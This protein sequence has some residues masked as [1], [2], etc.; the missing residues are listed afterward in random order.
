MPATTC[1]TCA[2]PLPVAGADCPRCL[3]RL[4]LHL[5]SRDPDAEPSAVRPERERPA[6]DPAALAR[7]FPGLEIE[8]E[9]GRGGM[10]VVYRARQR[11]LGRTVALKLLAPELAGDR[12]F[13]ARFLREAR[14][15]AHLRHEHIVAVHDFGETEGLCW[16]LMEHVDGPDLRQM[17]ESGRL[18]A[19][20]A[21]RIVPQICDALS[22]AHALG[23]VHRDI[24]P[25]NVLLDGRGR[26]KIVDF[27][28][29][30]LI[31]PSG[32]TPTLT[33]AEQAMGTPHYMAPEQLRGARDVDHRADIYSLGVVFYEMLTGQLP[34]GRFEAPSRSV[35]VDVRLDEIVLR[36]LESQPERRYQSAVEVKGDVERV[37]RGPA[38]PRASPAR[39]E[40]AAVAKSRANRRQRWSAVSISV[41]IWGAPYAARGLWPLGWPGALALLVL[42]LLAG[43]LAWRRDLTRYPERP[44]AG[45]SRW[46]RADRLGGALLLVVLGLALT[47]AM[48]LASWERSTPHSTPVRRVD[49]ARSADADRAALRRL[50]EYASGD[51]PELGES[52]VLYSQREWTWFD[53]R[54]WWSG[55]AAVAAF[56]AASYLLQRGRRF[57]SR[58]S[59]LRSLLG[60]P[61]LCALPVLYAGLWFELAVFAPRLRSSSEVV[62]TA[63]LP[64]FAD[65]AV[66]ALVDAARAR[67]YEV[68][69][70]R[71]VLL[72]ER[73]QLAPLARRLQVRLRPASL[74]DRWTYTKDGPQ[75]TLP[76]LHLDALCDVAQPG[77]SLT[78]SAGLLQ[79]GAPEADT[80]R[81]GVED[82][83][84]DALTALQRR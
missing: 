19:A 70:R 54:P 42:A 4:G 66:D 28:L 41:L 83:V 72:R 1:P 44:E 67:G 13:A 46:R 7:L 75:R 65:E 74:F 45:E 52:A 82:L 14:V 48:V 30:K 34:I 49:H 29:A 22:A 40:R 77:T 47:G 55:L 33:R 59:R 50:D 37:G 51:M 9:I 58:G 61:S 78:W 26:A 79:L 11:K 12:D 68:L 25:E 69:E 38:T 20:T 15:L 21:L 63:N 39:R 24:K 84:R 31:D 2:A 80:W 23:V 16:L 73:A 53:A 27:G 57:P 76:E 71:A 10:G 64:N 43:V 35:R 32:A 81:S 6:P 5:P 56:L 3:L 62:G 60:V 8:S 17:M 18:E 36:A